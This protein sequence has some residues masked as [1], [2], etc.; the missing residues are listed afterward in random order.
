MGPEGPAPP[1]AAPRRRWGQPGAGSDPEAAVWSRRFAS[2]TE[3]FFSRANTTG[4]V[5][6]GPGPRQYIA[7]HCPH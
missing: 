3:V 6:W 4:W 5:E 1:G 7:E 2:G